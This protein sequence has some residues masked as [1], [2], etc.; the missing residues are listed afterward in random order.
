MKPTTL[1]FWA[2]AALLSITTAH[3]ETCIT[4]DM[5]RLQTMLAYP[6]ARVANLEHDETQIFLKAF[7]SEPRVTNTNG[8][9]MQVTEISALPKL[10]IY[11]YD[12][13]GCGIF[14]IPMRRDD[15]LKY[16]TSGDK[17]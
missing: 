5:T 10:I 8:S 1:L 6:N 11:L 3:A 13:K 9:T 16:I 15:F 14:T 4:A 17:T 7:N 12:E 2:V